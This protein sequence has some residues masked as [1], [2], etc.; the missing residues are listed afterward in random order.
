MSPSDSPVSSVCTPPTFVTPSSTRVTRRNSRSHSRSPSKHTGTKPRR[1]VK[2]TATK[3]SLT[4][5][6]TED[7]KDTPAARSGA[8]VELL[9]WSG[10]G[11]G[12]SNTAADVLMRACVESGAAGAAAQLARDNKE[13]RRPLA[14]AHAEVGNHKAAKRAAALAFESAGDDANFNADFTLDFDSIGFGVGVVGQSEGDT[15]ASDERKVSDEEIH[16]GAAVPLDVL[17]APRGRI[18]LVDTPDALNTARVLLERAMARDAPDESSDEAATFD[19]HVPVVGVDCE[20]RPGTKDAP[21][22]VL[23]IAAGASTAHDPRLGAS[24]V[25][26]DCAGAPRTG[27]GRWVRGEVRGI[28]RAGV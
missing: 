27:R 18:L 19:D 23:Q 12:L 17:L 3:S 7:E 5:M 8:V 26:V 25:L 24:A 20:W 28:Y 1:R 13:L 22:S 2:T 16:G 11:T 9:C 14:C 15:S 6:M 21:V 4:R 10:E